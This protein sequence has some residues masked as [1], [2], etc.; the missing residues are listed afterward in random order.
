[1]KEK[2]KKYC[3]LTLLEMLIAISIFTICM[4]GFSVLFSRSIKS[5]TYILDMGQNSFALAQG[6][7]KIVEYIREARQGDNG[8]YPI[9]AAT[10]NSLTIYS[11]YNGDGVTERLHIYLQN[12]QILMGI[13]I[14]TSSGAVKIYASG[15]QQTKT[16]S[17]HIVNGASDKLFLYFNQNYPADTV[18]NPLSIS[19][20][21]ST[22]RMVEITLKMN[23]DPNR[24][25]DNVVA[26]SFAQMRNLSDYD[27]AQ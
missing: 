10:D 27:R 4:A 9:V 22:I 3:G 17:T 6:M 21:F 13:T 7:E 8:N 14:P 5:N 18:N 2:R 24:T 16:I 25:S 15:D 19:G 20:D 12:S 26:Q 1:M 23:V 11:D